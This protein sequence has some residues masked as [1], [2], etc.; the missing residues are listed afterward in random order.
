MLGAAVLN[1]AL[2]MSHGDRIR[3]ASQE[4]A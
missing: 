2:R 1:T 4:P 3:E